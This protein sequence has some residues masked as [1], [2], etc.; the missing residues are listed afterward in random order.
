MSVGALERDVPKR[1]AIASSVSSEGKT[2][3]NRVI[4]LLVCMP[5]MMAIV[6][7]EAKPVNEPADRLEP[8]SDEDD[9]GFSNAAVADI[10]FLSTQLNPVEEAGRMRSSILKDFWGRVDF[11]PNDNGH[12]FSQIGVTAERSPDARIL[13]GALHGDLAT[14]RDE[15]LLRPLQDIFSGLEG[16]D[17]YEPLVRLARLGGDSLYYVPWMQASFVM[18]ANRRALAYLPKGADIDSL[19]YDQLFQWARNIFQKTGERALGFPVGKNGL[20][21]RFFQGYLY[22][23]FTGGTLVTFKSRDAVAMWDYFDKLWDYAH[24]GSLSYSSMS[25]PLLSGDVLIAWDHTARLSK[26]LEERPDDFVAFPAPIGPKGRGYMVVVSGLAIP[27]G[28]EAADAQAA[29]ID[30]LTRPVIQRRTLIETGFFPV[31]SLGRQG[32]LPTSLRSLSAAVDRQ[33]LSPDSIATLLPV[34][35][36][37][38]GSDYNSLYI[39]TFSDIVLQDQDAGAVLERNA[40]QLQSLLDEVG[41]VSWPPDVSEARPV[42]IE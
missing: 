8:S 13:I 26:A 32:D 6:A 31:V 23:S 36:G 16:R 12:L 20:M 9:P 7:C 28:A 35:L 39:L 38:R 3:K 37:E 18:V 34:G 5:L 11:K 1:S 24:P 15:G 22:P 33:A 40:A 19:S 21:H 30:Y 10:I 2:N 14:L 29:L 41:A 27:A 42:Q 17:F 4:P 25:E